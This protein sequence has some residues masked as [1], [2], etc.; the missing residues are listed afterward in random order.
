[1]TPPTPLE[2]TL[3]KVYENKGLYLPLESTLMKKRGRGVPPGSIWTGHI[4]DR[5]DR[6]DP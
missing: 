3:V 6:A 2:S 5:I 1:M 4:P